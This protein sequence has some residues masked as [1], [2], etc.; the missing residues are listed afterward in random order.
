MAALGLPRPALAETRAFGGGP[1]PGAGAEKLGPPL[2]E[3]PRR[4][5]GDISNSPRSL[6]APACR[7]S[8]RGL[9]AGPRGLPGAPAGR[10]EPASLLFGLPGAAAF[11]V[12]DDVA[13]SYSGAA[14]GSSLVGGAGRAG[15]PEAGALPRP[16]V[17]AAGAAPEAAPPD[18]GW[19]VEE[20]EPPEEL[21]ELLVAGMRRA[22]QE[23]AARGAAEACG[24]ALDAAGAAAAAPS[25]QARRPIVGDRR[26]GSA[27]S[28]WRPL[29][30]R[31]CQVASWT[32]IPTAI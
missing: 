3:S 23:A 16:V 8:P 4:V 9:P 25:R 14:A 31:C 29:R 27:W 5:L 19:G 2:C 32:S 22:D 28:C 17:A 24:D 21:A 15:G 26:T 18:P 30:R 7:P 10:S 11:E 12:F 1:A 13:G 6:A 20:L